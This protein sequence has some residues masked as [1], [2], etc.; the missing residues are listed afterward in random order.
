MKRSFKTLIL[1]ICLS[2]S[3]FLSAQEI[4]LNIIIDDQQYDFADKSV[5]TQIK[6][7]LEDLV[8]NRNWTE[9]EFEDNERINLSILLTVQDKSTQTN[10]ICNAQIQSTRPVYN[11]A[12]ESS[13][14]NFIDQGFNFTYTPGMNLDFND[15][16][17]Q[18]ELTTLTAFYCYMALG[19]DYD[20]F[21]DHGGKNYYTLANQTMNNHPNPRGTNWEA[22]SNDPNTRYWL[23]E[24]AINPQFVNFSA[25]IYA[26]H[27]LG[28]D[29]IST[30]QKDAQQKILESLETI[31]SIKE[32]N[33]T[34]ILIGSFMLGK[35]SELIAIFKGADATSQDKVIKI[36]RF[37]D[38]SNSEK[39][40]GIKK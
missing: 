23:V 31:K 27:R 11:A 35:R 25:A 3:H 1:F 26:Y 19:M 17:Y 10:F 40:L 34:S 9:D 18:A 28:L 4:L 12:Y 22:G 13:L 2:T 30:K 20:S 16:A 21:S 5:F 7:D 15:N 24:N 33:P 39:Y 6:T 37:L 32:L 29:I 36:L 14:L 8:N 38:P